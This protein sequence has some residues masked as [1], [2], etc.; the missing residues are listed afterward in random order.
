MQRIAVLGAGSWGTALALQLARNQHDVTLWGHRA[1]HISALQ[2][3][4][5]NT[6]YLPGIPFPDNLHV[7]SD[8]VQSITDND[9]ILAVVPSHAF[10]DLLKAVKPHLGKRPFMWAI[11]GFE[12]GSGRLLSDVFA[13]II[14]ADHP[15]AMLAGP[16]FAKEV[17]ANQPTAV[18]IAA[19]NLELA[20]QFAAHFHGSVFLCYTSCDLIGVQIA[21]AVKNVI[22]IA[23]GIADG[24]GCGANARAALITRGLREI[25]RLAEALGADPATMSGLA[26]MG[27]LVLTATDNQSRNRRFGL[28]LGKGITPEQAKAEIGQVVEG[29]GATFDTWILA[30]RLGVR[31]PITTHLHA[32]LS[33]EASLKEAILSLLDRTIKAEDD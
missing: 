33:G 1:E 28:A 27:D 17:A 3:A 8:L 29:E 22:A 11:K 25:S 10:A 32:I 13:D 19:P 31:M 20:E 24:I 15:H 7:S 16:S 4:R 26:G 9:V 18:T 2:N 6:H 23:T 21:G 5:E 14:G 12:A 30:N